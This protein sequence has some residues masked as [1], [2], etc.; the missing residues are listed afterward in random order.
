[1]ADLWVIN[2][3][4]EIAEETRFSMDERE[5]HHFYAATSRGLHRY[6]ARTAGDTTL[7][8]DLSQEAYYRFLRAK[9]PSLDDA[10]S[11]R[12]LF[13][14]AT[15]LFHDHVR[16]KRRETGALDQTDPPADTRSEGRW[17]A[18]SDVDRALQELTARQR[19]L[20]WLA[21]VEG[22]THAEVADV[23]GL[24]T[25]SIRPLLFRARRRMAGLLRVRGRGV[26]TSRTQR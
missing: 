17:Q 23:L 4:Q 11:R 9:L 26:D 6:L 22:M 15:N 1:M 10:G 7:A 21:Y 13:R 16:Q 2:D 8:D 25:L 24:S 18:K 19:A 5:F 14:I 12:Y 20:L 3:S